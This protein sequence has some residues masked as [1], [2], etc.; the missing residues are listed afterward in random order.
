M[1]AATTMPSG[2]ST[3]HMSG[4]LCRRSSLLPAVDSSE[5]RPRRKQFSASRSASI[6]PTRRENA[7]T[8][9]WRVTRMAHKVAGGARLVRVWLSSHARSS[10]AGVSSASPASGWSVSSVMTPAW[11]IVSKAAGGNNSCPSTSTAATST[12]PSSG[13]IVTP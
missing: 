9:S 1:A 12:V 5:I 2:A 3:A 10:G 8:L 6:G 13:K 11:S 7:A 4:S